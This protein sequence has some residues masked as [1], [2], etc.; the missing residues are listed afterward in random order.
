MLTVHVFLERHVT[1]Y[2]I[3]FDYVDDEV[4]RSGALTLEETFIR[5]ARVAVCVVG[6]VLC[7][8]EKQWWMFKWCIAY[9]AMLTLS[10][11]VFIYMIFA[12]RAVHG[13]LTLIYF[14]TFAFN[15]LFRTGVLY[16]CVRYT[17]TYNRQG[18]P[19]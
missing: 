19:L 13:L 9:L 12:W 10:L 18:L 14:S 2:A 1:E 4:D 7:Y 3:G 6:F 8:K 11:A 15:L 17:D 5:Y 16:A